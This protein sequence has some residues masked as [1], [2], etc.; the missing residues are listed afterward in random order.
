MYSLLQIKRS[1]FEG[2]ASPPQ[3]IVVKEAPKSV[4]EVCDCCWMIVAAALVF[5]PCKPIAKD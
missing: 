3:K 1:F 2:L 5:A 4:G